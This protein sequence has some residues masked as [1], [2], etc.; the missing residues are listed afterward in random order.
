MS[1]G[2][3]G[4]TAELDEL[5]PEIVEAVENHRFDP[6]ERL[7]WRNARLDFRSPRQLLASLE[8]R[9]STRGLMIAREADD[10]RALR[11]LSR[12][13]EIAERAADP[14]A[15]AAALGGVP[16][17]RFPQGDERDPCAAPGADLSSPRRARR[18]ACPLDWVASQMARL[19]RNDGDIDTLMSRIAHIRTWTYIAHRPEWLADSAHWQERARAIE[20]QLS[21]ALHDRITQRFVDRRSAFLV[22]Q[23]ASARELLA[24]VSRDGEVKVEGHYVGR[25]DGFRFLP[26]G[27]AARVTV[28]HAARRRQPR[29]ARRDRGARARA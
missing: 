1:D 24:S 21:D 12:N 23:L 18:S 16:D 8:T 11:A 15:G 29:A 7:F 5:D 4:T 10:H 19:D 2:T 25:L 6:L 17:P 20:D 13:P 28:A 27:E 22:R 14:A 26:D 3:F 9:P